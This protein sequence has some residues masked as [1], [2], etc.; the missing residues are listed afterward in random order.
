MRTYSLFF[1]FFC[2]HLKTWFLCNFFFFLVL[3]C[4]EYDYFMKLLVS[5]IFFIFSH[6]Y[7][8]KYWY[9]SVWILIAFLVAMVAFVL[10]LNVKEPDYC[11]VGGV[12]V[13][14]II[15]SAL[16]LVLVHMSVIKRTSCGLVHRATPPQNHKPN[17][18]RE[19]GSSEA[20]CAYTFQ[21]SFYFLMDWFFGPEFESLSL[22]VMLGLLNHLL[23][24]I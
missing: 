12:C 14:I 7:L 18:V 15:A 13:A 16:I 22:L 10:I 20:C 23:A 19:S 24:S 8:L 5:W 21:L 6:Y 17:L 11:Q 4:I 1:L 3:L 9:S 2:R